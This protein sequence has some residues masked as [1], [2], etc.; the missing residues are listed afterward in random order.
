MTDGL[1]AELE[2]WRERTWWLRGRR[3]TLR[4]RN[5]RMPDV[6][7]SAPAHPQRMVLLLRPA[8][9]PADIVLA[10]RVPRR[11]RIVAR[12][13]ARRLDVELARGADPEADPALALRAAILTTPGRRRGLASAL[14]R[15]AASAGETRP[16]WHP[17]S[18]RA[19]VAELEPELLALA[20]RLVAPG[21]VA[22]RGVAE[23]RL[24][25]TDGA[26]PLHAG[27]SDLRSAVEDAAR[28]LELA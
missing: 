7:R 10:W 14:K 4:R 1:V 26:R 24:L 18:A 25:L 22:A 28:H 27:R 5:A 6:G 2:R 9:G 8:H 21:P 19:A 11:D 23:V 13:H 12:L 17:S 15:I 16:G 3:R 20:R